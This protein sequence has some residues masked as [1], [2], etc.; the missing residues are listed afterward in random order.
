MTALA[1]WATAASP[2][3]A[4]A[5]FVT[6]LVLERRRRVHERYSGALALARETLIKSAQWTSLPGPFHVF[7]GY[8]FRLF[9]AMSSL[10]LEVPRKYEELGLWFVQGANAVVREYESQARAAAQEHLLRVLIM[11]NGRDRGGFRAAADYAARH[12]WPDAATTRPEGLTR[13]TNA[14]LRAVQF[15][16]RDPSYGDRSPDRGPRGR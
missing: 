15:I 3:V 9:H 5:V 6:T 12:P 8:G 13:Y 14:V 7:G 16:T 11:V 10:A 2:I 1:E 4:T